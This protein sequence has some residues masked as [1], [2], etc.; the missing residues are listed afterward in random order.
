MTKPKMARKVVSQHSV[1]DMV[2]YNMS[3]SLQFVSSHHNPTDLTEFVDRFRKEFDRLVSSD[4][5]FYI[6][7]SRLEMEAS[8]N[9]NPDRS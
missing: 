1:K 5:S 3:Y 2:H 9:V 6:L 7:E 8:S 4:E